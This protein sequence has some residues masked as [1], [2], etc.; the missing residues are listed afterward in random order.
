MRSSSIF[1]PVLLTAAA[2]SAAVLE[3]RSGFSQGQPISDDGKGAR[4]L[5]GTD[6]YIDVQNPDN[7]GQQSTDNGVVPNLKWRFSDSKTRILKGGWVREQVVTDLPSSRDIAAAQQ[8]LTK[9]SVRELHWHRVAEWG[10]VYA[11]SV[12]VSAVDQDG[13]FQV[14]KLEVGDVWYFPKGQGHTVQ[15][16]ED[17]N[18]FLLVFDDGDFDATGTTF[19]VDDWIKHTPKHILAKNFGLN[20]SVFDSVPS[21]NPYI[22]QG[23]VSDSGVSGGGGE[24]SGDASFVYYA[25]D[26][27]LQ[28]IPGGGGTL[29]IIDTTTFPA[30][31]TIAATVVTLVPGGLRE[32][33]WHP[34]AE[35]WLYFHKGKARATVFLGSGLARTFDFAAGDTGVFPSNSGHYIENTGDSELVWIEIYKSDRVL[36]NPLTQWLALTPADL[37]AQILKIPLDVAE[38]LKKDKQILIKPSA[39]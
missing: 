7:L 29:R 15:G 36:D 2:V 18:E 28:D 13:K 9:G 20:A 19:N 5:G 38:G 3:K 4:I 1:T 33:H 34:N 11:G 37:V 12:L 30:S 22:Q 17:D 14:A 26:H 16:L 6:N 39:A 35:E 25:K 32:L 21:P 24:L 8:H 31:K 23:N 10:Y 27:A